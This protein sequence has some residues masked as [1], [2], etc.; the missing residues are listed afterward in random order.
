V[1]RSIFGEA[2]RKWFNSDM[3]DDGVIE[4]V[5]DNYRSMIRFWR[6]ATADAKCGEART[7]SGL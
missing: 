3:D 7:A 5:A 2:A 4:L 1:G 6:E